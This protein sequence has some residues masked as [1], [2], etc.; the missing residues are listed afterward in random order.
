VLREAIHLNYEDITGE[1]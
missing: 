1:Q